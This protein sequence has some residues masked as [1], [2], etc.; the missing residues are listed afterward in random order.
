MMLHA[1]L[2]GIEGA[3]NEFQWQYGVHTRVLFH[4][5]TRLS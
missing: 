5:H 2:Y 4:F 1:D 3:A